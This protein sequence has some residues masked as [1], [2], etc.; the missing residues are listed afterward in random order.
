MRD[1]RMRLAALAC[2]L[3]AGTGA[4]ADDLMDVYRLARAN[5]PVL[6]AAGA[7][8]AQAHDLADAARAALL[9]QA[10][11]TAAVGRE[12][13]S[14][15]GA[16]TASAHTSDVSLDVTQVLFDAALW[17]QLDAAR[18]TARGQD[19]TLRAAQQSLCLRVASAYFDAL[20]A[21][22]QLASVE[23]DEAAYAQQVAQSEQ[24]YRH[25]LDAQVDVDQARAYQALAH[26]NTLAARQSLDEALAAVAEI[27]GATPAA[28]RPLRDDLPLLAPEPADPQAWIAAAVRDNPAVWAARRDEESAGHA[29]AA[30]RAGHLPS[31][32][33]GLG[34]DRPRGTLYGDSDGRLTN[35][36]AVTLKVPLFSGGATQAGVSRAVHQ[37]EQARDT[38]ESQRRAVARAAANAYGAVVAGL[39]QVQATRAAVA[40]AQQS[41]AAMRV[42]RE[43][44]NRTMTDLLGAIETLSQAQ[45]AYARARHQF[46]LGRLQLQQAAGTLAEADLAN[47]NALLQ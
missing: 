22:D 7:T 4:R 45:S 8:R 41:L 6:A 14:G 34:L 10:S 24:R 43:L 1:A 16:A 17:S 46:I 15:A 13:D 31:L 5:D 36:V 26:G 21:A 19:D 40:A 44:G 29:I 38:L 33:A 20:L 23:S 30:A 32:S 12:R 18:A 39:A 28:L 47:V 3:L 25:G 2:A 11:A 9:P 35:V 27:T 37:R 42:G